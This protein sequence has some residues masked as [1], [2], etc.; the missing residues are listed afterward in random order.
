MAKKHVQF[1]SMPSNAI[2]NHL[3]ETKGGILKGIYSLKLTANA[4]ENGGPLEKEIP[5]GNHH[6]LGANC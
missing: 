1:K 5:I 2:V 4:P 6:F 3:S